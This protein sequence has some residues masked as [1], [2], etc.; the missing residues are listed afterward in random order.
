MKRKIIYS[1]ITGLD[2]LMIC[3]V[4]S[5]T[6][7]N[8]IEI[9]SNVFLSIPLGIIFGISSQKIEISTI[10]IGSFFIFVIMSIVLLITMV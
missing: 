6:F 8:N 3:I 7:T 2:I 10:L 5:Y 4:L 9:I 1:L